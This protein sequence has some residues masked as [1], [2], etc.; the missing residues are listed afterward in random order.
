MDIPAPHEAKF[1][2]HCRKFFWQGCLFAIQLLSRSGV[3]G[4]LT[5][6]SKA[7][8]A[9][10]LVFEQD[11]GDY[12]NARAQYESAIIADGTNAA[13]HNNLAFILENNFGEVRLARRHFELAG[14]LLAKSLKE[15]PVHEVA[16][17]MDN[18]VGGGKEA[19]QFYE[20]MR[21]MCEDGIARNPDN[22][23]SHYALAMLLEHYF[24]EKPAAK[25]HFDKAKELGYIP[26]EED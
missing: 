16:K 8:S 26:E 4:L 25:F 5:S 2:S 9:L 13:A 12:V 14:Q 20:D 21:K 22:A 6:E 1:P 17:H 23:Q 19:R 24:D 15:S 3:N 10:G 7:H 18:L 11:F